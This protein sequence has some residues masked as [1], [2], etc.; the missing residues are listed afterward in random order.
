MAEAAPDPQLP[1]RTAYLTAQAQEA[2]EA[3][4]AAMSRAITLN[5]E[6]QARDRLIEQQAA[7]IADQAAALAERDEQIAALVAQIAATAPATTTEG[8]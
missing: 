7:E 5:V 4:N 1:G 2:Q 6:V 3:W 8:A